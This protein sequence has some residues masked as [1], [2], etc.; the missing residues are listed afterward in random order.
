[1]RNKLK[2][3]SNVMALMPGWQISGDRSVSDAFYMIGS[4]VII[5]GILIDFIIK[6]LL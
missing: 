3:T 6:F 5:I 2:I 4:G 1:V